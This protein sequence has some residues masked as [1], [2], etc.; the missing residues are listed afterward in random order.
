MLLA[1][2]LSGQPLLTSGY[3]EGEQQTRANIDERA[4]ALP[5]GIGKGLVSVLKTLGTGV[6]FGALPVALEHFLGDNSTNTKRDPGVGSLFG[7]LLKSLKTT[8]G[9]GKVLGNGL[10]GGVA[11]GVGAVG[12]GEL[13]NNNNR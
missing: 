9:L 8:D 7:D 13:L 4:S 12:A 5:S 1:F 11:S 2:R 3:S 6:G 10:L